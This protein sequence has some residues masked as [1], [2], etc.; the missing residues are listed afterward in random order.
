MITKQKISALAIAAFATSSFGAHA[1]CAGGQL[2]GTALVF[3]CANYGCAERDY[4]RHRYYKTQCVII[5]CPDGR[6]LFNEATCEPNFW[7]T[8]VELD[9]TPICC[10]TE[11]PTYFGSARACPV[12]GDN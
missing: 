12:T 2:H 11:D 4:V 3:K 1:F 8:D 10:D 6:I 7:V 9:G 5:C